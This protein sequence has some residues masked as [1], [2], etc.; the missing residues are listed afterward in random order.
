VEMA[1][2]DYII[3][4]IVDNANTITHEYFDA[5]GNAKGKYISI[6]T[7][8]ELLPRF[9]RA[10]DLEIDVVEK[11]GKLHIID[12]EELKF[13]SELGA[14]TES[15]EKQAIKIAQNLRGGN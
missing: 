12:E 10:I 6:T 9:A 8:I 13:A 5:D 14:I 4:K 3:T 11:D 1:D 15:T 7:N 2:Q